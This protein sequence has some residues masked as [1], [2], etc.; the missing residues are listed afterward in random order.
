[1]KDKLDYLHQHIYLKFKENEKCFLKSI[2]LFSYFNV[3]N[4]LS[5][6][7]FCFGFSS[8]HLFFVFYLLSFLGC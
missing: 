1:M 7:V 3:T 2:L 6:I 4:I 8:G 5:F